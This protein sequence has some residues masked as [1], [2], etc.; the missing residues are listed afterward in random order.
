MENQAA[1]PESVKDL[2]S[3]I[4]SLLI[5][6]G[7]QCSQCVVA[8]LGDHLGPDA[9]ALESAALPL[10]RG[11]AGSGGPCGALAG[12]LLALGAVYREDRPASTGSQPAVMGFLADQPPSNDWLDVQPAVGVEPPAF[13]ACRRLVSEVEEMGR[14]KGW[15]SINCPD[16]TGVDWSNPNR[17]QLAEY[18]SPGGEMSHC[19]DV[20]EAVVS[21]VQALIQEEC[22][23]SR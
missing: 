19:L 15:P 2:R 5:D 18:Y 22:S 8:L 10:G 12:G 23:A 3:R 20:I 7:L 11:M 21:R 14:T 1:G 16:I 17:E 4:E 13:A 9:K 6:E